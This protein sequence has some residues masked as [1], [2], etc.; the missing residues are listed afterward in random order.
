MKTD[1]LIPKVF[2]RP[3]LDSLKQLCGRERH[4]EVFTQ[5]DRRRTLAF[6]VPFKQRP[7]SVPRNLPAGESEDCD[8]VR[9]S[10]ALVYGRLSRIERHMLQHIRSNHCLELAVSE[11]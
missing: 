1:A 5:P 11:R 3:M 10:K 2:H 4:L 8:F 9:N 7:V 6:D